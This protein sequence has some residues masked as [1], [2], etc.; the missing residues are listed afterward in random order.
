MNGVEIIVDFLFPVIQN[1]IV[2][3]VQ[4]LNNPMQLRSSTTGRLKDIIVSVCPILRLVASASVV[5]L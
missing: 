3:G 4:V 1:V 5:R 2:L